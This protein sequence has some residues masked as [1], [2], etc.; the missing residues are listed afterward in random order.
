MSGA[1]NF[2]WVKCLI[3]LGRE[4]SSENREYPAVSSTTG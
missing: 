3:Y 4:G 1:L 2:R